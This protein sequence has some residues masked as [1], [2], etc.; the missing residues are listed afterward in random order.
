L[1]PSRRALVLAVEYT[2]EDFEKEL[3]CG[4]TIMDLTDGIIDEPSVESHNPSGDHW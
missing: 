2:A 3:Q 1:L 4:V